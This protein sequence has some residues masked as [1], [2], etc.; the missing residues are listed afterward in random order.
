M[1]FPS[2]FLSFLLLLLLFRCCFYTTLGCMHFMC[3]KIYIFSYIRI[4]TVW[5]GRFLFAY[6]W[7]KKCISAAQSVGR[8]SHA[9]EQVAADYTHTHTTHTRTIHSVLGERERERLCVLCKNCHV[10]WVG[11]WE[12]FSFF[13]FL[14]FS[15]FSSH[16]PAASSTLSTTADQIDNVHREIFGMKIR[17]I[18]LSLALYCS[19]T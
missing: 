11:C 5:H 2:L 17:K 8:V 13:Y 4:E 16:A 18:Y 1:L 14:L 15:R 3:E 19:Y 10:L 7:V 12:R 9:C 6:V